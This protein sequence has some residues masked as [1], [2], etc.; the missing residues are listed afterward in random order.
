MKTGFSTNA[1]TEKSLLY[2]IKS[3]SDIGYDGVEIVLDVP[4]AF[5]PIKKQ[6]LQNI[7]N[8]IKENKI[9]V[10]NLNSNTVK[11][12]YQNNSVIEKFEPSLSNNNDKLRKWRID[13]SKKSN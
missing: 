13:Y 3:I 7:K 11:G 2:S 4:H 1:F 10:T 12:W 6:N 9:E 8:C 5:L